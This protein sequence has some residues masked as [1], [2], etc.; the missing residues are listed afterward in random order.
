MNGLMDRPVRL[1]HVVIVGVLG[2]LLVGGGL[3]LAGSGSAIFPAGSVRMVSAW[4]DE[5]KDVSG[6]DVP[7]VRFLSVAFNV[8]S[9]RRAD[10]QATFSGSLHPNGQPIPDV[11]AFCFGRITLDGPPSGTNLFRPGMQQLIGGPR[12]NMPNAVSV[13]MTGYRKNV[14]PGSHTVRV[15]ISSAFEGCSFQERNLNVLVNIR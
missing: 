8:P 6:T 4:S 3:A 9:G 10:L 5:P 11:F 15:Y 2:M 12:A 13:A 14:G 1:W 7:P